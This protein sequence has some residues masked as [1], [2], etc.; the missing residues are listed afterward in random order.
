[1]LFLLVT[2]VPLLHLS[3]VQGLLSVQNRASLTI[4]TQPVPGLQ[5]HVLHC[6]SKARDWQ[7]L[8]SGGPS[9]QVAPA[10]FTEQYPSWHSVEVA[11]QSTAQRH[12]P[13]QQK[14][15]GRQSLGHVSAPGF[16]QRIAATKEAMIVFNC[17]KLSTWKTLVLPAAIA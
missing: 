14:P 17:G 4:P 5:V 1:M 16:S 6:L 11:S 12:P 15:P 8:S 3:L 10:L 7:A 13:A 2:Q 9:T